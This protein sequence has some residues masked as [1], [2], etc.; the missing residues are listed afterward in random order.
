LTSTDAAEADDAWT[1]GTKAAKATALQIKLIVRLISGCCSRAWVSGACSRVRIK[2]FAVAADNPSS[3]RQNPLLTLH[4]R[5]ED[6]SWLAR[7][8]SGSWQR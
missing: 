1:N 6:R 8:G 7:T 2:E 4:P 3:G 5:T